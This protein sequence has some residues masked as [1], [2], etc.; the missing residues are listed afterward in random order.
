MSGIWIF[1]QRS[2]VFS[3]IE[4]PV[5]GTLQFRLF[6]GRF[7]ILRID[8]NIRIRFH[9]TRSFYRAH[10]TLFIGLNK[11]PHFLQ[12]LRINFFFFEFFFCF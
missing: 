4:T 6:V 9:L 1:T 8:S 10:L 2:P 11:F 5:L 3:K 12:D 7:F